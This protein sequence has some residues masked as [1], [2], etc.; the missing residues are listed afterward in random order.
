MKFKIW[1]LAFSFV[2]VLC[3]LFLI[4]CEDKESVKTDDELLQFLVQQGFEEYLIE[5][6]GDMYLIDGD[7]GITK[8]NL[9]KHI[10]YVTQ[11]GRL[12]KESQYRYS[13]LVSQGNVSD[14]KVK[15]HNSLVESGWEQP[16]RDAIESWNNEPDSKLNFVEVVDVQADITI[17]SDE[18]QAIPPEYRNAG[19]YYLMSPGSCAKAD[20]PYQDLPGPI[21]CINVDNTYTPTS[22]QK[23]R[24]VTHEL[25]HC[26][27]L[28]HD[29]NFNGNGTRISGTPVEDALS[30]MVANECGLVKNLSYYDKLAVEVLYPQF[31]TL[32]LV[33][34]SGGEVV[35]YGSPTDLEWNST[36]ILNSVDIFYS[37]NGGSNWSTV[38]S[39]VANQGYYIWTPSTVSSTSKIKIEKADDPGIYSTSGNF[40][41]GPSISIAGPT[42]LNQGQYGTWTASS[43]PSGSYSYKWYK[44]TTPGGPWVYL[45]TGSFYSAAMSS[46]F[47]LK[48][49]A[50]SGGTLMG[51]SAVYVSCNNCGGKEW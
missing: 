29:N 18:S 40:T 41:V 49:E 6:L 39:S 43:S 36:G 15:I 21:I 19:G 20:W 8:E 12:A 5:D 35:P 9:R 23:K 47:D 7:A 31:V 11:A 13:L 32:S 1:C 27:G 3:S 16:I 4:S 2:V 22:L 45:K 28:V 48:A 42:S 38:A 50:Y 34:P 51:Q 33:F 24:T 30:V 14:I 10:E 17:Y 44:K 26:I 46:G 25:G 37:S